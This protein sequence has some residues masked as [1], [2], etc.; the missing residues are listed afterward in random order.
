M[1]T[2]RILIVDDDPDFGESLAEFLE[3]CGFTVDIRCTGEAGIK[4]A[5][6]NSYEA[7]LMDIG[8]SGLNGVESLR[9]IKRANSDTH[10]LL[11]S[12]FTAHDLETQ[13][14]EAGALDVMEKPVDP[15]ILADR[16]LNLRD[17][18]EELRLVVGR[19]QP[20]GIREIFHD[21]TLRRKSIS[22]A[23]LLIG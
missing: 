20:T 11:M 7:I 3:L 4:A 22:F 19:Q 8:L 23:L 17:G 1:A 13:A 2:S 16:L 6:T 9:E 18:T 10:V 12:G 5:T 14:I 15:R 21:P